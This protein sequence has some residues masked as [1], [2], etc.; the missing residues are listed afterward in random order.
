MSAR[1]RRPR[2]GRRC[3]PDQELDRWAFTRPPCLITVLPISVRTG[4]HV[5]FRPRER[6]HDQSVRTRRG[7]HRRRHPREHPHRCRRRRG[8]RRGP[9][10]DHG[11]DHGGRLPAA[12][13]L[14]RP[15]HPRDAGVGVGRHRRARRR[16]DP[17]PARPRRARDR[18]RPPATR[19]AAQRGEVRR[20]R[21]GPRCPGSTGPDL[22]G[23]PTGGRGPA[24]PLGAARRP[25]LRGPGRR[26][27]ATP[28]VQPDPHRP[29]PGPGPA[30][31]PDARRRRRGAAPHEGP[32]RV[33]SRGPHRP[34]GV[35]GSGPPGPGPHRRG[36][37]PRGRDPR[38]RHQL[39]PGP[40]PA[41]GCRPDLRRD[42]ALRLVPPRPDPLR[43]RVR[44]ARRRRPR[45]P[46]PAARPRTG[47]AS[48]ATATAA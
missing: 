43:S 30:A 13:R 36:Q 46:R 17:G 18:D 1:G 48:T 6:T 25:R 27:R 33:G 8:D 29:R 20:P 26:R 9:R 42:R 10:V 4:I 2:P 16:P 22:A 11:R 35:E 41:D 34:D 32:R 47:T 40:A 31:R 12:A 3:W 24:S 44:H 14:R 28:G 37:G 23:D 21:R 39:A 5:P 7:R 15:A 19:R 38:D 45:S